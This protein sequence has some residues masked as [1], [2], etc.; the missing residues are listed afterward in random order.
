MGFFY[1][2]EKK[3]VEESKKAKFDFN[4]V[5]RVAEFK[6]SHPNVMKSRIEAH[7]NNFVYDSS[8]AKWHKKDKFIQP[9]EDILGFKFGEYKNYIKV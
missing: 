3:K 8:K 9:I 7:P 2:H 4:N 5:D 6:D 1:G